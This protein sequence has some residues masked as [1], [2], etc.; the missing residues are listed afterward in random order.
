MLYGEW[1]E[2]NDVRMLMWM[3]GVTKKDKTLNQHIRVAT[4]AVQI[5][6]SRRKHWYCMGTWWGGIHRIK[7]DRYGHYHAG[8][9]ADWRQDGRIHTGGAWQLRVWVPMKWYTLRHG[10][11]KL[12]DNDERSDQKNSLITDRPSNS[13]GLLDRWQNSVDSPDLWLSSPGLG[14]LGRVSTSSSSSVSSSSISSSSFSSS[15][16]SSLSSSYT[17]PITSLDI[18][19]CSTNKSQVELLWKHEPRSESSIIVIAGCHLPKTWNQNVYYFMSHTATHDNVL[20][21]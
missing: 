1:R 9:E 11:G 14:L 19:W 4:R 13:L 15:F 16:S 2:T 8:G 20:H 12:T 3:F 6:R 7:S 18:Q 5:S 17:I 21:I 10:E